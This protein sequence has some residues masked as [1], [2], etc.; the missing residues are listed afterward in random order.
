MAI[1][2]QLKKKGKPSKQKDG[3]EIDELRSGNITS[4]QFLQ[5]LSVYSEFKQEEILSLLNGKEL[6]KI[7]KSLGKPSFLGKKK[8]KQIETLIHV[9]KT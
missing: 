6:A 9:M 3:K 5:S 4:D 8:S 2:Q 7:L 1:R